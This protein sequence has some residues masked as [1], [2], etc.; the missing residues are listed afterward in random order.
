MFRTKKLILAAAVLGALATS[1]A[2]AADDSESKTLLKNFYQQFA[3]PR[4]PCSANACAVLFPITTDTITVI[5][6]VSCGIQ[7]PVGTS[8]SSVELGTGEG[9][10]SSVLQPFTFAGQAQTGVI[11]Y[12][13][14]AATNLFLNKG[15]T[16]FVSVIA[17]GASITSMTCT[18]SGYHS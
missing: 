13:I 9:E 1:G 14:N 6:A 16:P 18:I 17:P 7:I 8:I 12:G 4:G 5:T 11:S 2:V 15:V 3:I 10:P